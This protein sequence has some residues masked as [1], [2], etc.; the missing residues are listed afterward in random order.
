MWPGKGSEV[1]CRDRPLALQSLGDAW[2]AGRPLSGTST[3]PPAASNR[4]ARPFEPWPEERSP[5][6]STSVRNPGGAFEPGITLAGARARV[7]VTNHAA[8]SQNAGLAIAKRR[9]A[10]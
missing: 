9:A 6:A 5:A 7:L 4:T 2:R 3:G 8:P 1:F 10:D